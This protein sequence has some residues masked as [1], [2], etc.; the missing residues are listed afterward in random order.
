[1]RLSTLR[2]IDAQ[3]ALPRIVA[4]AFFLTT[5]L[6]LAFVSYAVTWVML[7]W[8]DLDLGR[9]PALYSGQYLKDI[10]ILVPTGIVV[11]YLAGF[12][13]H[14]ASYRGRFKGLVIFNAVSLTFL[15]HSWLTS[16]VLRLDLPRGVVLLA[17]VYALCLV[18]GGRLLKGYVDQ[19]Y[20]IRRKGRRGEKP[21]KRVLLIG[22]AGYIGS[23][24]SRQLLEGGFRVRV[25]DSL[26]FGKEPIA[27]LCRDPGFELV[28]A[29]FRHV[30][31]V[32]SAMQDMDAVIHLG[33]IV[34]D[35]ACKLDSKMTLETNLGATAMIARVC[36]GYGI[37]RLLFAS[38]CSVYGAR[39]CLLDERS[40][41][42]P[43]S[44]YACT[45][46]DSERMLLKD[47]DDGLA[48]TVLRLATA[49]GW[50]YR[51]RLDLVVSRLTVQALYE[52][53]ITI[54]NRTQW[55]PFIHVE[56][57]AQAFVTC[58][59]APVPLVGHEI[60]NVGSNHLNTTLGDLALLV[61]AQIP[62]V[63]IAYVENVTDHR[64]YRV[65]FDKISNFIGFTCQ[66]TLQ[67]GIAGIK[68]A[69]ERGM[70]SDY[71]DAKY[72]NDLAMGLMNGSAAAVESE[73]ALT[74][75]E[76]FLRRAEVAI[77]AS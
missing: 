73:K 23:V 16:F 7:W 75:S 11:F 20:Q 17:W 14:A 51:P 48:P 49:F 53:Q 33:G 62:D 12:Y 69:V 6:F 54:L 77:A 31:S 38:S 3:V 28:R 25:L 27:A 32:V 58:L 21:V 15:L 71:R 46:L 57:I 39:E 60:F 5:A 45:K 76:E 67:D 10:L 42:E 26:L 22:G 34:G 8:R 63:E 61:K 64:N 13:T 52:H 65:S 4:D 43:V 50:S 68:K 19:T 56:D 37:Q 44:L 40:A 29:D 72:Y 66:H 70:I 55:R 9:Y 18:G 1:M 36:R 2:P 41:P 74:T 59:K 47:T 35:P 30:E 24:L